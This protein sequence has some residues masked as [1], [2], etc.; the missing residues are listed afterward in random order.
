MTILRGKNPPLTWFR[1]FWQLMGRNCSYLLPRQD[2]G[3]E[4]LSQRE[5]V[6]MQNGHPVEY[7][8]LNC[9]KRTRVAEGDGRVRLEVL[10]HVAV[11]QAELGARAGD[12]TA[13]RR[14]GF[15]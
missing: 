12:G 6:T 9:L 1:H 4:N 5:V 11:P 2:G 8:H 14:G 7:V 10:G 15:C 13:E 3:T